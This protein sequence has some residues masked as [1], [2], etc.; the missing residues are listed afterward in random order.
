MRPA[1]FLDRDGVLN[2]TMVH[3]GIPHPPNSVDELLI[4]PGVKAALEL[5]AAQNFILVVVTNQPDVARGTQTQAAVEAINTS[6]CE[7]LPLHAVYVCYHDTPDNCHCRKPKPGMLLQAAADHDLDLQHSYMLG[8]RWSDIEAGRAAGCFTF[9]IDVPYNQQ[10]R[11]MPDLIVRD[12]L[13]AAQYISTT[14]ALR[15]R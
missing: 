8:D 9:L 14:A 1:V 7:L 2:A 4:L 11:C 6:L 10:Q 5:L 3:N 13:E 15:V 12:I